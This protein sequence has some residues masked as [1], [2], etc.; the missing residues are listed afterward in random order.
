MR[1]FTFLVVFSLFAITAWAQPTTIFTVNFDT[2]KHELTEEAQAVITNE[3][4]VAI[5]AGSYRVQLIGHTDKRGSLDYNQALSERRAESVKKA[6]VEHGFTAQNI[7]LKGLA[8][9]DPLKDTEE[10]A[11]FAMNRRVEVIIEASHWNVQSTYYSIPVKEEAEIVYERSAL[12]YMYLQ[13]HLPMKME[14]L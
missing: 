5:P 12:K 7:Q 3:T 14:V 2:D 11:D 13:M 8:F 10:E 4:Q 1:H 6:L 9:L